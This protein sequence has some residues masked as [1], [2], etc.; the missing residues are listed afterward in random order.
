MDSIPQLLVFQLLAAP[1]EPLIT[2]KHINQNL[3]LAL[4]QRIWSLGVDENKIGKQ[5]QVCSPHVLYTCIVFKKSL[6][7]YTMKK[8]GVETVL[9]LLQP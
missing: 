7:E 2:Q 9:F 4:M 6:K 1:L 8:K 3:T 5:L